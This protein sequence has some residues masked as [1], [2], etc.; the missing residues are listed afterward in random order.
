MRHLNGDPFGTIN[1]T[2]AAV[3]SSDWVGVLAQIEQV[4][5]E[6][7]WDQPG[8]LFEIS[9]RFDGEE[10]RFEISP[11]LEVQGN[12]RSALRGLRAASGA[13][14][15]V[16]ITEAWTAAPATAGDMEVR[17]RENP[18]R[19]E[20]RQAMLLDVTGASW[21]LIRPRD[22]E[23]VVQE[24]AGARGPLPD[25]LHRVLGINLSPTTHTVGELLGCLA[26]HMATNLVAN[27]VPDGSGRALIRASMRFVMKDVRESFQLSAGVNEGS[28]HEHV[29]WD[30]IVQRP[31][32]LRIIWLD[33]ATAAWFGTDA[34]ANL[35]CERMTGPFEDLLESIQA[36][37]GDE[38]AEACLKELT[39]VD[40]VPHHAVQVNPPRVASYP[41]TG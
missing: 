39:L 10:G 15:V 32:L 25:L 35:I 7:G 20:I 28:V 36:L 29:T 24:L 13:L 5:A 2:G 21:M 9:L 34:L 27:G 6:Q 1:Y 22:G 38:V 18:T 3:K 19:Q 33:A 41:S 23:P 12:P 16:L 11:L 4:V 17:P 26:L 14:A 30:S 40:W 31:E 8:R 37:A